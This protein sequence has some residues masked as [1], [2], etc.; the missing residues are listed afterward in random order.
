MALQVGAWRRGPAV[1][2]APGLKEAVQQARR[3]PIVPLFLLLVLLVIPALFADWIAP[4]DPLE[5]S[6]VARLRPPAWEE[7]GSREYL[8]GTDK[9]GRDLLSRII[10]G[11]RISLQ[12]S[13]V[14]VVLSGAIG[15]VLGLVSGYYGGWVDTVIM[16][17]VDIS[18]SLP[19]VL[20]GL[21]L[22]IVMG[23]GLMTVVVVVSLLLWSRYARQIRGE[24]LAIRHQDY[25]AR[26][27][28]AGSSDARIIALHVFPNVVNTLIVLATLNVGQVIL[29]EATLSFLG[30]GIP[31]P[32]PS[33]GVMVA[34]G[35]D[36]I[37]A[38]WWIAMVPGLAIMLVVLAMNMVGDW[39]RDRLDPRL[40][41][42]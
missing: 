27:K 17:L 40:R 32:L 29:L 33:W 13:L 11:A 14:A 9:Q 34:D 30:A 31:R 5:G 25:I 38:A 28:V 2:S 21:V 18:L 16:R 35:R 12:V 24:A 22:V 39:L 3:L 4:Y 42:A 37:V 26:A 23:P 41:Q 20:I 8:L 1:A 10:H 6:L 19:L 7:G 36:H 15:T